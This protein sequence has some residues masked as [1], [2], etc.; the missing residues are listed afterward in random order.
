MLAHIILFLLCFVVF[1]FCMSLAPL[2]LVMLL[3]LMGILSCTMVATTL[4]SWVSYLLFLVYIGGILILF[5]FLIFLSTNQQ[6]KGSQF[7]I[8]YMCLV[9]SCIAPWS[10]LVDLDMKNALGFTLGES[11]SFEMSVWGLYVAFFLL[12]I[13]LGVSEV[14]SLQG[15]IIKVSY[16]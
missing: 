7:S 14:L 12:L 2:Q 8:E 13:F 6:M 3:L 5:M 10:L 16:E 4:S 1:T 11:L 9:L 15:R